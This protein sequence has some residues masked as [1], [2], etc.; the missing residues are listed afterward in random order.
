VDRVV[1]RY[2]RVAHGCH[3]LF[4]R[5]IHAAVGVG[6]G[7]GEIFYSNRVLGAASAILCAGI[8]QTPN[9][10]IKQRCSEVIP[11]HSTGQP[12]RVFSGLDLTM[13]LAWLLPLIDS[14][15][16]LRGKNSTVGLNY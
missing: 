8:G 15:R 2:R 10:G 6:I 7:E 5:V 12:R 16:T 11:V 3:L 14:S 1:P 4:R 9:S 13:T